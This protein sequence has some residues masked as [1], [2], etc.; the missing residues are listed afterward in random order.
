M[1]TR[2]LEAPCLA[3]PDPKSVLSPSPRGHLALLAQF[4]Q[5][6]PK[7]SNDNNNTISACFVESKGSNG[8]F[9]PL[10]PFC[11][12]LLSNYLSTRFVGQSISSSLFRVFLVKRV[13]LLYDNTV[14][15]LQ[16]FE[17]PVSRPCR[18]MGLLKQANHF[19]LMFLAI[20]S[21][22]LIIF[23]KDQKQFERFDGAFFYL[24]FNIHTFFLETL[25]G[26][27]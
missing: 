26:E 13:P 7:G 3:A 1:R 9:C 22:P 14:S 27:L 24:V 18:M 20:F 8:P 10:V 4:N 15:C 16:M 6:K 17:D 25:V 23:R 12:A 19:I 2:G 21:R 5:Q 11:P